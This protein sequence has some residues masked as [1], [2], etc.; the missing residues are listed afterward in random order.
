[1]SAVRFH[2][3]PLS[4]GIP[5]RVLAAVNGLPTPFSFVRGVQ[6]NSEAVGISSVAPTLRARGRYLCALNCRPLVDGG[7]PEIPP[8]HLTSVHKYVNLFPCEQSSSTGRLLASVQSRSFLTLFQIG[9]PR[10]QCGSCD[11]WRDLTWSLSSISRN[12]LVPRISGKFALRPTATVID[13]LDSL[14]VRLC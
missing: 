8:E 12:W 9:M 4:S 10:N 3:C 13:F 1:M 7:S 5:T 11:W 2:P 6:Q 14:T